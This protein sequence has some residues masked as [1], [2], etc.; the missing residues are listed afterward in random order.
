MTEVKS[1]REIEKDFDDALTTVKQAIAKPQSVKLLTPSL[2][3][4]RQLGT[5]RLSL[6][7]VSEQSGHARRLIASADPENPYADVRGRIVK[8][9]GPKKKGKTHRQMIDDLREQVAALQQKVRA[10][11]SQNM[12]LVDRLEKQRVTDK[13]G[14]QER[15]N[16]RAEDYDPD[17]DLE[18]ED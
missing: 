6:S 3:R 1:F 12:A 8:A 5:L 15:I 9:I 7:S 11:D 2:E 4:R 18:G 13:L 14:V 10:R 16:A 17:E